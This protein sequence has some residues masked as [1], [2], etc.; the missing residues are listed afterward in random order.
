MARMAEPKK[1][2]G[3]PRSGDGGATVQALD[4]GLSLLAILARTDRATLTE[5]ALAAGM[6]PSTAHRMLTTMQRHGI[7]EFDESNQHWMVGV[8][9]FRI[10]ASFMRRSNLVE[11]ARSVM[12]ELMEETGETANL[13]IPDGGDVVFI[14]QVECHDPIRAFFRPGTRG[15]MHAS[16]IGKALLAELDRSEVEAILARKGLPVFTPKTLTS[17][18]AL[19]RLQR[20]WCLR[21]PG[22]DG[23]PRYLPEGI[24]AAGRLRVSAA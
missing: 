14:G 18:A 21:L 19:M 20:R 16:G 7:T 2:R 12:L 6:A 17:L 13:A 1:T 10:G 23:V 24:A 3:R 11:A 15:Y 4:R 9:A 5:I 8:E 22:N